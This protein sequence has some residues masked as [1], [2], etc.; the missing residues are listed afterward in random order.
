MN[1][2]APISRKASR[3]LAAVAGA[4][5][6]LFVMTGSPVLAANFAQEQVS[7]D[8]QKTL[9]LGA[10]QSVRVEHKFGEVRVHGEAGR[11]VKISATIRA[12]A[13][14]KEE[15]ESFVQKIQIEV[16]QTSEGVRIKTIYPD[17]EK[18]WFHIS[19]HSSWS[20]SYDIGMPADAPLNVRNS[21]G[22][23]EVTRIHGSTDI[24]NSHGTLNVRD[25]GPRV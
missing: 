18:S 24:E 2:P 21:F 25:A 13:S 1:C 5:C 22:S 10:G 9:T 20:V 3:R 11:D 7:R 12:Q 17:E 8:F 16:Q 6:A 4:L 14:S 19:R 15:A 23:V